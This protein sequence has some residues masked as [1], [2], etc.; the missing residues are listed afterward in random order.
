MR[1]VWRYALAAVLLFTLAFALNV[2]TNPYSLHAFIYVDD[3][4]FDAAPT[5]DGHVF[6]GSQ[7][8]DFRL[9]RLSFSRENIPHIESSL[10]LP[11]N[12]TDFDTAQAVTVYVREKLN[13]RDASLPRVPEQRAESILSAGADCYTQ[14]GEHA[15]AFVELMQLKGLQSRMLWMEGHV[16]AEYFDRDQL[17]W[18]YIDP[19]LGVY[20]ADE[21]GRRLS[22]AQATR[23]LERDEPLE[24]AILTEAGQ[25]ALTYREFQRDYPTFYRNVLLNGEL[26]AFSGA[27]LTEN[28]RWGVL[29]RYGEP[30][31]ALVRVSQFDSSPGR[32]VAPLSW[33]AVGVTFVLLATALAATL[34][35]LHQLHRTPETSRGAKTGG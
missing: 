1:T 16:T 35:I 18:V 20:F 15:R 10:S 12:A 33:R 6:A 31:L 19:H 7:G 4:E 34:A 24:I 17:G 23:R 30:S 27:V 25:K 26:V 13:A 28:G 21:L 32:Y 14:C 5:H 9:P 11:E 22:A 2:Y 3:A 8:I 29:L